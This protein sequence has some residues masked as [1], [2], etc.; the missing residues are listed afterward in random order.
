MSDFNPADHIASGTIFHGPAPAPT[1][2][3][4]PAIHVLDGDAYGAT[5]TS[6]DIRTG[7][8]LV[9][10]DVIGVMI[11]AWPCVLFGDGESIGFHELSPDTDLT[12]VGQQ[13]WGRLVDMRYFPVDGPPEGLPMTDYSAPRGGY[14]LTATARLA[15]KLALNRQNAG[16]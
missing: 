13:G 14:D 5:Q 4:S 11:E 16:N 10:G 8:I 3:D 15:T 12:C 1:V 2:I 6:D 7:D 9:V